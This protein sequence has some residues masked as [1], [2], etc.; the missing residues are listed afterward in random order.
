M[1]YTPQFTRVILPFTILTPILLYFYSVN[2]W[3]VATFFVL[4]GLIGNGV[5]GHRLIAHRQFKPAHW[6]RKPL[7]LICTLGAIAPVWYWR[8]QHWHHH[9]HSDQPQDIHSPITQSWFISF[10]GWAMYNDFVKQVLA[11]ERKTL[12]ESLNDPDM[13]IY[14]KHTYNIVWLWCAILFAIGPAILLS[15]LVYYWIEQFRFGLTT[16]YAHKAMPLSYRNFETDEFSQNNYIIGH[17]TFGLGW[18]N[19]HHAH[20]MRLDNQVKWWEFDTEAKLA[21]LI[22]LIPGSR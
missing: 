17:L 3:L 6:L 22:T 8:I 14:F 16:T 12:R 10:F 11:T 15:Y 5:I 9:K 1:K 19:N 20:P 2:W 4:F 7:L 13:R 18:H 21:K